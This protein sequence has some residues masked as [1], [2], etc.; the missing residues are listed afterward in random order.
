MMSEG[1]GLKRYRKFFIA[2]IPQ[3]LISGWFHNPI[4]YRL[5]LWN[6]KVSGAEFWTQRTLI[7][8]LNTLQAV[9]SEKLYKKIYSE[10]STV[11]QM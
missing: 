11:S 8:L 2:K 7:R 6:Y 4:L 5:Y 10:N 9:P 3:W 1:K